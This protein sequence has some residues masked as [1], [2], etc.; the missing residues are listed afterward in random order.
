[1]AFFHG[2]P[3]GDLGLWSARCNLAAGAERAKEL[4]FAAK[5]IIAFFLNPFEHSRDHPLAS[6]IFCAFGSLTRLQE[7]GGCMPVFEVPRC[8]TPKWSRFANLAVIELDARKLLGIFKSFI[9]LAVR[10]MEAV[11]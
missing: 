9:I 7:P 3:C 6:D 10:F 1:M 2:L 8:R 4:D 11:P 5:Y